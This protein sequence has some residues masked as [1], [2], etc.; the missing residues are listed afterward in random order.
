MS[1]NFIRETFPQSDSAY[2]LGNTSDVKR[3]KV[4]TVLWGP[5][6]LRYIGPILWDLLPLNIKTIP[7]L[8]SC[9]SKVKKMG[10][11]KLSM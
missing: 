4:N 3:P 6:T 2:N 7:T 11:S 9:I 5:E 10:T 8:T 1:P